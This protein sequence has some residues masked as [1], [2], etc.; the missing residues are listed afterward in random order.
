[1]IRHWGERKRFFERP[2]TLACREIRSIR[3]SYNEERGQDQRIL[4][5]VITVVRWQLALNYYKSRKEKD[6]AKQAT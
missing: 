5:N 1:M 2:L 3:Q 6:E 4:E